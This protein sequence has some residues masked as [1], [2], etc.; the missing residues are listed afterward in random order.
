[1]VSNIL[2]QF[3][4]HDRGI[5]W[6]LVAIGTFGLLLYV[7]FV[8][9]AVVSVVT[10]K[11]AERELGRFTA[12]VAVLESAY[13]LLDRAIDLKLAH[14][15]G[16]VDVSAPEY[17]STGREG[18]LLRASLERSTPATAPGAVGR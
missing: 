9:I 8:G 13:A 17:I 7:Y 3:S 15:Q 11:E 4:K 14:T 12:Q 1:M 18:P 6:S 16:F 5:F 10:R 2:G